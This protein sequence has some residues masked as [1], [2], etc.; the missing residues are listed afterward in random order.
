[1]RVLFVSY[2]YPPAGGS[3]VQRALKFSRYLPEFDWEP[4]VLTVRAKDAAWP[5]TD[6]SLMTEIPSIVEIHRTAAW[7]PYGAYAA[8]VGKRKQETVGVGFLGESS[9]SWKE[10]L[11]RWLRANLFLPDA[12]VG[13]VPYAILRARKLQS[14]RPFDAVWTTG[15]PH[16]THLVGYYLSR[17]HGIPWVADFRDPWTGIDYSEMLPTTRLARGV[18]AA[19]EALVLR[20][21]IAVTVAWPQMTERLRERVSRHY[22]YLPNGFDPQDFEVT[23]GVDT[24][25]FIISHIGSLNAA[26]NPEVLWAALA[27]LKA[28]SAMPELRVRLVGMVDPAVFEGI[29]R[30]GLEGIIEHL[31]YLE[32]HAAIS[33]MM[34]SSVLLLVVNRVAVA[35]GI[36]PG[37][38]FEYVGSGRPVFCVG[39]ADGAA[40]GIVRET[41]AGMN[42]SY[43]DAARLSAELERHYRAWKEGHPRTG[44]APARAES[45]SRRRQAQELATLLTSIAAKHDENPGDS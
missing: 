43:D 23:I 31:S 30:H 14:S 34:R 17:Y 21:A 12:R 38:L 40:A 1:M 2:Y 9:P 32:H 7:D 41:G 11:G 19:L 44:A 18:D 3:G 8:L 37:K 26:R 16:S 4:V 28:P 25:H 27:R 22:Q 36:I 5:A 15:P 20:R 13:W 35:D 6:R 24:R 45:Y 33:H 29:R 39:P 10:R 42:F